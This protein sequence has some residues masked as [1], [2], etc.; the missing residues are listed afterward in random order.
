MIFFLSEAMLQ[1]FQGYTVKI[2]SGALNSLAEIFL[3][4]NG[5]GYKNKN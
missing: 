3:N 5:T 4:S 2:D 1:M